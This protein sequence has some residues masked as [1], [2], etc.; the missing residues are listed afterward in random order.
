M[1]YIITTLGHI[2]TIFTICNYTIRGHI[3][4][5]HTICVITILIHITIIFAIYN[6]YTWTHSYHTCYM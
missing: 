3:V 5:I 1:L 6:Y 2:T 4:I